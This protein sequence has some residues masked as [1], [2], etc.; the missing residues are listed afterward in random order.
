M[1]CVIT[2]TTSTE[3]EDFYAAGA[4]AK[5][6]DLESRQVGLDSIFSSLRGKGDSELLIGK[7]DPKPSEG[8]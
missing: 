1:K 7:R 6:P 2:Y 8:I 5:V 3:N 4:D